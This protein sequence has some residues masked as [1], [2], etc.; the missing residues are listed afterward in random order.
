M[1]VCR[2]DADLVRRIGE[3][4]ALETRACGSQYAFAPCIA[5]SQKE[6][7]LISL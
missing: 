5:V 2:R 7:S 1:F 4:T 3:V 6:F